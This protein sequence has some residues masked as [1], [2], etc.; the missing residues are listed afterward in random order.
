MTMSEQ[1]YLDSQALGDT[2]AA[3][4][5]T[6][7]LG[8]VSFTLHSHSAG[9]LCMQSTTG[10]LIQA[11]DADESRRGKFSL[12]SDEPVSLLGSDRAVSPAEYIL[13]GLAGCYGVTLAA[14]AAARGIQLRRIDLELEFDIDL[15]GFLGIDPDVRKGA[16]EIKVRV[17]LDCPDVE[18]SVLDALVHE[19]EMTSPIRD[20]LANPVKVTTV[21]IQ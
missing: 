12:A 16:D 3:V 17:K 14:C 15:Q 8:K 20:T 2:V 10:A 1:P 9:G 5:A 21:R 13:Q 18:P 11:G 4:R 7:A 19:V 6:P